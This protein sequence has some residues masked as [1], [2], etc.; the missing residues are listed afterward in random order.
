MSFP[1]LYN[2]TRSRI[3]SMKNSY[4]FEGKVLHGLGSPHTSSK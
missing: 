1:K 3:L 2:T 4:Y